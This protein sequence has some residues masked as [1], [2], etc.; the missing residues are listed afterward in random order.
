MASEEASNEL[1]HL[2]TVGAPAP[3]DS[4]R[5]ERR[6]G[7]GIEDVSHLFL[8]QV[9]EDSSQKP[10]TRADAADPPP[11][12]VVRAPFVAGAA[13]A[14]ALTRDQLTALLGENA[15][16]LE[17]GMRTIDVSLPCDPY[18]PIDVLAIDVANRL[19]IIDLETTASDGMLLRGMCHFDWLVHNMRLS[20]RMYQ[21]HMINGTAAPRIFLVAP[22]F[23]PMLLTAAQRLTSPQVTCV[24]FHSLTV[25][26]ITGILLD[27]A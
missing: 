6:L 25:D 8:S 7:R 23:S 26:G 22:Q 17:E 1:R 9:G 10:D 15:A 4:G 3:P 13:A 18:S 27:R 21:G 11:A 14:A 20:R 5:T 16:A 24:R 2:T 12:K 19:T